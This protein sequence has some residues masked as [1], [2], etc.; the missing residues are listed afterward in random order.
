MRNFSTVDVLRDFKSVTHAAAREP[1]AITQHRK[2]RFVMMAIEDFE[3]LSA[4][5][6]DPRRVVLT[7][8]SP[9]ELTE[10]FAPALDAMIEAGD[11]DDE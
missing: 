8:Q 11:G 7:E 1:V 4:A 10:I 9:P 6:K 2:V 3:Q 5:G